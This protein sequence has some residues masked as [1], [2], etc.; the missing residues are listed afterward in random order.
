MG[1]ALRS[2]R[3]LLWTWLACSI[4]AAAA[5]FIERA[6]LGPL[7]FGEIVSGVLELMLPTIATFSILAPAMRRAS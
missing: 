7:P 4:G 5:A 2:L 6:E 1:P 3:P